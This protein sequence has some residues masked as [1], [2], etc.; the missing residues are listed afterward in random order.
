LKNVMII[1]RPARKKTKCKK[2]VSIDK[3][4]S[5]RIRIEDRDAVAKAGN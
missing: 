5:H 1:R 4:Y 2:K 3:Q